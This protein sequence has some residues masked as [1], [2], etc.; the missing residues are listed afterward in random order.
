[1]LM[2]AQLLCKNA[3]NFFVNT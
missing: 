1:M 3:R 2:Y